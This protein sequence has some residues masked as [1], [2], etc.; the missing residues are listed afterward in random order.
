[1]PGRLYGGATA[2]IAG[3]AVEGAIETTVPARTAFS[4]VDLKTYFLRPVAPDGRELRARGSVS[5][6]GRTVAIATSEVMDA[7]G[8]EVAVAT[9]SALIL[10]G[11][12]AA[13]AQPSGL[14]D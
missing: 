14:P 1:V 9:G 13:L 8:K 12:A 10:P 7:D 11:R 5:Y 3:L 6:R 4:A 2:L